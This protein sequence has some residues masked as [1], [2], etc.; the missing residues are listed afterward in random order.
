M[1]RILIVE[2]EP[3]AAHELTRLIRRYGADHNESFDITWFSSAMNMFGDKSRYDI[4]FLDIELP[5][6]SG[7]E[8]AQL[9]R[10]YDDGLIIIFVTN[11]ANYAVKGYEVG[12]LGFIVKPPTYTSLSMNL[13][14][15][16]R[17]LRSKSRCAITVPTEDDLYVLPFESIAFIEVIGHNLV[18]HLCDRDPLKVRGT[19]GKLQSELE[20]Q[21]V[22]RISRSCLANMNYISC[23]RGDDVVM[24]TGDRL[25]IPRGKK[26]QIVESLTDYLGRGR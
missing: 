10:A 22:L 8:A 18:Y 19:L 26:R 3:E 16:L 7:M 20:G 25:H 9:I 23:V 17:A 12:A 14:R 24:V 15:S 13:S 5:G 1:H 21:A 2:D 6:I 11:L 4:C